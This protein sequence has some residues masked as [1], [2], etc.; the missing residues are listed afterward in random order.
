MVTDQ[1]ESGGNSGT[2]KHE[3]AAKSLLRATGHQ[4][5]ILGNTSFFRLIIPLSWVRAPPGPR[6]SL[7]SLTAFF[8]RGA[9]NAG[10]TDVGRVRVGFE[11]LSGFRS[12]EEGI[13]GVIMPW[14]W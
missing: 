8:A 4:N 12:A 7:R 5:E 10:A 6:R 9:E 3:R 2:E 13:A 11:E 14:P 1:I